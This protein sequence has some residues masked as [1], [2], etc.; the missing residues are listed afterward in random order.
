MATTG[1]T[2]I[3]KKRKINRSRATPGVGYIGD[4]PEEV[5]EALEKVWTRPTHISSDYARGH[6]IEIA[7]L[8]SLGW[9]SN[10]APDG[11][12]FSR[13]WC[14]TSQGLTALNRGML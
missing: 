9:I 5:W 10:I 4:I 2:A 7:I 1:E 8:A 12:S 13:Q 3:D 6:A 11:R 14:I